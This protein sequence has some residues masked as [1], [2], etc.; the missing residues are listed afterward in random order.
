MRAPAS[1]ARRKT[2]RKVEMGIAADKLL[3]LMPGRQG[4]DVPHDEVRDLQIAA[5]NERLDEQI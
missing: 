5:I 3:Q 4:Y 1:N 2:E